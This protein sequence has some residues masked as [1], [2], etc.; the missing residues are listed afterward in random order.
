MAGGNMG[1]SH[2]KDDSSNQ[3]HDD[4]TVY[5][6][7][8]I[9]F[10]PILLVIGV[11]L[12][13]LAAAMCI[14]SAVDW[15]SGNPDWIVFAVAAGTT[16]FSGMTL[17]LAFRAHGAVLSIRQSFLMTVLIWIV[18]S[19]FAS[20][21]FMFS[22]LSLNFTDAFFESMSGF[23]TTGSTVITH[24]DSLPPGLLLW[25]GILQWLGG[26][27]IIV[28]AIS[29]LPALRVGGMQMFRIEAFETGGKVLPRVAQIS[30][31]ATLIFIVITFVWA[32]ALWLAG[33]SGLEAV[34]H[35]MT[36][37]ATGGYSS[38]DTSIAHFDDALIEMIIT[39]GMVVGGVPFL[40]YMKLLRGDVR[41]LYKDS[42]V[43]A[44]LSLLLVATLIIAG[45]LFV[46]ESMMPLQAL[47]YSVFSTVSIMTGTG[48]ASI[49]YSLWGPL[50]VGMLFFLTFVGGCAGSTA[51]GI[52]VFR[53]QILFFAAKA[54]INRL[55]Q[56][57]GVFVPYYNGRRIPEEVITS[58]MS[59]FFIFGMVFVLLSLGL[60][61]VG[62]D[63]I[64]AI[65]G[66]ATSMANVGPGFGAIIGPAGNFQSLPDA[67]KW[68][69]AAGMLTGRLEVFTVIV[70]F[71]RSFWRG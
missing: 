23:T 38:S 67:A 48:Y 3:I 8:M 16:G 39:A 4:S 62:L 7:T 17:V 31:A 53:F 9:D 21:P 66:A 71:S 64:T 33:M 59:F 50:P 45:W 57:H 69:L 70:L 6:L 55:L 43:Q 44:Y 34:I 52:K 37:I 51:C 54:Q 26:L 22:E 35:S 65:T 29:I 63:F 68:L 20:L 47:R 10:R 15:F 60:N 41:A 28:M 13:A 12:L 32:I 56:P 24:L 5:G 11:L 61:V 1:N 36:T 2:L 49:D 46:E 40:L 27:G 25:R 58:V 30:A 42:Q 19:V 18:L 14:P